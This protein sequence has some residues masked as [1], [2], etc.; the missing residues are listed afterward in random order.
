MAS[1]RTPHLYFPLNTYNNTK[2]DEMRLGYDMR[3]A[4]KSL[5]VKSEGQRIILKFAVNLDI[6]RR[7]YLNGKI[8][9]TDLF[10]MAVNWNWLRG[11]VMDSSASVT[12]EVTEP[13]EN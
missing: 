4:H 6:R 3:N 10:S 5:I 11:K 9:A 13:C 12:D 1:L 2:G 7:L 8:T